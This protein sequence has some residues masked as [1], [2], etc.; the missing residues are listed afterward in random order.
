M[1]ARPSAVRCLVHGIVIGVAAM[2]GR[3]HG[4][5][6]VAACILAV[7]LW[8]FCTTKPVWHRCV[9]A[10]AAGVVIGFAPILVGLLLDHRFAAMF[11]DSIRFILFEYKGTNLP[12]PVPWPWTVHGGSVLTLS[13][14][15]RWLIGSL[16]VLLPL[17][18][19]AG[20]AAVVIGLRRERRLAHPGFVACV[21]T[22]I[23]YLNVAFSRADVS[24][25]AQAICPLVIG[26][27]LFPV[28]DRSRTI[29]R[30]LVVPLLLSVSLVVALQMHPWYLSKVQAGWRVVDVRGDRLIMSADAAKSVA[31]VERLAQRYMPA[32]S[33]LLAAPVW[34]GAYALLG[35]RSPVWEIYPLFP[36]RDDFQKQE[37]VRL[38]LGHPS[39]ILIEDIGVDGR[40]DLRYARTHPL[41]WDY[42]NAN[43]RRVSSP[44]DPP[45]LL[46]YLPKSGV[47]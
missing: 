34:P 42:L 30:W 2:V 4:V 21:A 5:Y 10:W 9:P 6:G 15:T 12:L 27:L 24:H 19:L 29:Y 44:L 23:P 32:G 26:L 43:Y 45:Q 11:W 22:A 41:I 37:I 36:R 38:Q 20:L 7:P 35:V 47:D 39:L 16:F 3:N 13:L 1:L 8:L 28:G 33:T 18:C 14:V 46:V 31:D 17:F 25:L 40:D